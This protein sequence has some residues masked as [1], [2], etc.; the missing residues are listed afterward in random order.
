[1]RDQDVAGGE[2]RRGVDHYL[3]ENLG[4][5]KSERVRNGGDP[6]I[7]GKYVEPVVHAAEHAGRSVVYSNEKEWARAKDEL[8]SVGTGLHKADKTYQNQVDKKQNKK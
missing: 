4:G 2:G 1:M 6:S 3:S 7:Y 5:Y 8:K